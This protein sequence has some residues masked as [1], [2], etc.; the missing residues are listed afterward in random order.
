MLRTK[1][2]GYDL[3]GGSSYDQHNPS[4]RGKCIKNI[5]VVLNDNGSFPDEAK[6]PEVPFPTTNYLQVG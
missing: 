3:I 5:E 1:P 2:K 4:G 6:V